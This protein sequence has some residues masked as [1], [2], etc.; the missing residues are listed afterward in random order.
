MVVLE[1]FWA[2]LRTRL[3]NKGI[4]KRSPLT[5][6]QH[7]W[8]LS[9]KFVDLHAQIERSMGNAELRSRPVIESKIG[10]FSFLSTESCT[11]RDIDA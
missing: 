3:P 7:L 10:L 6:Q 11:N 1:N 4:M 5:T 2:P 8:P 9:G